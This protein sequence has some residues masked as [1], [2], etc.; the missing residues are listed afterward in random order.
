MYRSD[1]WKGACAS[2][3]VGERLTMRVHYS[4]P[5]IG[6]RF[7]PY[8]GDGGSTAFQFNR[9]IVAL[10]NKRQRRLLGEHPHYG[11]D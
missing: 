1:V 4:Q 10:L 3:A 6:H 9:D 8:V 2:A 11:Y 5:H 7:P